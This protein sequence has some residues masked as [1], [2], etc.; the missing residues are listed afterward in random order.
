[1]SSRTNTY[2]FRSVPFSQGGRVDSLGGRTSP[3]ERRRRREDEPSPREHVSAYLGESEVVSVTRRSERASYRPSTQLRLVSPVITT[4]S[5]SYRSYREPQEEVPHTRRRPEPV[6]LDRGPYESEMRERPAR[7]SR[8]SRDHTPDRERRRRRE[9]PLREHDER[10][11]RNSRPAASRRRVRRHGGLVG[12]IRG[13]PGALVQGL[14]ATLTHTGL[15]LF[16]ATISLV[17]SMLFVPVRNLYLAHRRLDTLQATYEAL[18]SE[19]ASIR[20]ELE[21]LQSREGIENEARARGYVSQ[22]ETKVVV[23]GLPEEVGEPDGAESAVA[24]L[25]LPDT[26][27]WYI[28]ALDDLFGYD[29][30]A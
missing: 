24:P 5:N 30:E 23:D 19:N 2:P 9:E 26:R 3:Q 4:T 11:S 8:G 29:P 25:E 12:A 20:N 18:E 13:L 17:L 28:R 16:V 21:V 14:G 6:E 22:G 27:T 15:V 10:R 1:M 7:R